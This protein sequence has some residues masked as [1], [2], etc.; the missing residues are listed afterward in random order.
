MNGLTSDMIWVDREGMHERIY[1]GGG[2]GREWEKSANWRGQ[3]KEHLGGQP[4]EKGIHG[5]CDPLM[6]S[7]SLLIPLPPL[8]ICSFSLQVK[9]LIINKWFVRIAEAQK[10]NKSEKDPYMDLGEKDRILSTAFL[11]M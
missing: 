9:L 3:R 6:P 7:Y 5:F 1:R 10:S 8:I 11:Q 2:G 4:A